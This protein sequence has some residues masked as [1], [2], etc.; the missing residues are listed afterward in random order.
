MDLI[1]AL[2]T[3]ISQVDE[4]KKFSSAVGFKPNGL[5]ESQGI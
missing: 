3:D 1:G 4:V 2:V 5:E